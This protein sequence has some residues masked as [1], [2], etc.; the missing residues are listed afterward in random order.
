MF[1]MCAAFM[2]NKRWKGRNYLRR[3]SIPAF[4]SN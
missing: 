4:H 2:R 1:F 3:T